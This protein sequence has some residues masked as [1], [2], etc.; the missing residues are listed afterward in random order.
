MSQPEW[1]F[2]ANLGD[3]DP[4]TYGGVFVFTDETGIYSPEVEILES[5]GGEDEDEFNDD[6][7]LVEKGNEEWEVRRFIIEPC[8]YGRVV[9]GVF[10]PL[11]HY[12]DDG[13]LS[14]NKFHPGH[15]AWFAK[16]ESERKERPQ[17]TTYLKNVASYIG[18]DVWELIQDFISDDLR[19][20]AMAWVSVGYYHGF[21]NLD[22]YPLHFDDRKEVEARYADCKERR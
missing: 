10:Q 2:F 16:P 9:D 22:S 7:E 3:A 6:G 13:I 1:K 5:V 20:K 4:I 11:D 21:D 15:A 17:D 8:T 19:R 12:E 18:V 14:D